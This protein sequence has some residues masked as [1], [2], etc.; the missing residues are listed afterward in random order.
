[1]KQKQLKA[2][3]YTELWTDFLT[4][5]GIDYYVSDADILLFE[6]ES[7]KHHNDTEFV[8][9]VLEYAKWVKDNEGD[10]AI[11]RHAKSG[12]YHISKGN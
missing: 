2:I 4:A 9:L 7:K 5:K 3:D 1:M 8:D 12:N 10:M 11:N 6:I